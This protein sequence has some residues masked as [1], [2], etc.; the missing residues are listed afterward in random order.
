MS[1]LSTAGELRA[2][3]A[4]VLVGIQ[5]GTIDTNK[6]NAIAKV[7]A[8]INQSLS[9]EVNTALQLVRIGGDRP[10][11]GNMVIAYHK[12]PDVPTLP[13]NAS[14]VKNTTAVKFTAPVKEKVWC[15]QCN[16]VVTIGQAAGCK[17]A[18]CKAKVSA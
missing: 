5:N 6:A 2:F 8:Q 14:A 7:S 18:Y 16:E 4:D 1:T 12:A 17:S 13:E 15:D 3:L 11:P 9:V 10:I